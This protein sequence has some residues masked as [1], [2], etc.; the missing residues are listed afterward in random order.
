MNSTVGDLGIGS[1]TPWDDPARFIVVPAAY[2]LA[3]ALGL[4][5]NVAALAVFVRIDGH[6]G[7]ALRLYLL[8][9]ALA[10]VLFTLTLPLWLTYYL[11]P[12]HWPFPE[13]ACRAAGAAYYVST[14]AAVAFVA[15]ISVCRCESVR[16]P[17]SGP[18]ARPMLRRRGPARAACAAAWLAGMACALPSL[19]TPHALR[20]G[21]GGSARCLEYGWARSGLAYATVAFFA[22]AFLLVLAAY[23]SLARALAAPSGPGPTPAGPHRRAARTMVLGLLLVFVVCLAPYHLLLAPWVARQEGGAG[24]GCHAASTLDVLH[25]LSLALLSLNSCLDPLIY[26][27]SVRRFRQDCW[28]LSRRAGWRGPSAHQTSFIRS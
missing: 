18:V 9:L 28:A 13:A 2:S 7:E 10:D 19:A 1:C 15:L 11:G 5:A 4:P 27:F 3:L 14:Y 6:L 22:A 24:G 23:V 20:P 16:G 25:T 17:G 21:P 12:A 26:C 8:N